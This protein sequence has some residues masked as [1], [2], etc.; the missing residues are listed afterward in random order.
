MSDGVSGP[1]PSPLGP[2]P[3]LGTSEP[4]DG[5]EQASFATRYA[6]AQK[7]GGIVVPCSPPSSP[8]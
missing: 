3:H 4:P 2:P 7:A 8:S 1:E 5:G 6:L